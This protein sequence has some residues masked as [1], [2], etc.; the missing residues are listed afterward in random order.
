MKLIYPIYFTVRRHQ[1]HIRKC[2]YIRPSCKAEVV[3][4]RYKTK[5]MWNFRLSLWKSRWFFFLAIEVM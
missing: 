1:F 5:I 2:I 4:N 3:S